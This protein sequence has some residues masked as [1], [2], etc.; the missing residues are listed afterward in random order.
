MAALSFE[1]EMQKLGVSLQVV[2]ICEV[3][4]EKRKWC[5]AVQDVL[6]GARS[7]ATCAVDDITLVADGRARCERHGQCCQLQ[8]EALV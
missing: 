4:P 1:L 2:A 6:Y 8:N 3:V 5:M 7:A